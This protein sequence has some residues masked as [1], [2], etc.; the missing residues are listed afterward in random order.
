M[1]YGGGGGGGGGAEWCPPAIG[2][3]EGGGVPKSQ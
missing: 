1:I 3:G 2:Y